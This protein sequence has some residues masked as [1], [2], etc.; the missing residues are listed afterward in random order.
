MTKKLTH[1]ISFLLLTFLFQ[2]S[3]FQGTP[4]KSALAEQSDYDIWAGITDSTVDPKHK[5][6]MDA[7]WSIMMERKML[8]GRFLKSK[9]YDSLTGT[10]V[11]PFSG[12]DVLNLLTFFP[13]SKRYILFGLEDPGYPFDWNA[14]KD[15][16]KKIILRGIS[17]LS[18]HL[19][20]R[21]YFTY[22]KMKEE[23]K[24]PALAGA[25]PVFTA[26]LRRMGKNIID[27]RMEMIQG[28]KETYHGFSIDLYDPATNQKQTLTYFKIFLTGKEGIPGDGVYEYFNALGEKSVFTKSAEYLFHGERRSAFRTLLLNN[29]VQVVQD[30]SG[31]PLRLF[32][33]K[34]WSRILYG[35]YEKSWK[36]SG[37]IEPEYQTDMVKLN[38][39]SNNDPLPFP[40][41][42][43]VLGSRSASQ[44]LILVLRKKSN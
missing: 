8:I 1:S 3:T 23:T 24:K 14:K 5:S 21:N 27:S 25:Y 30:D 28:Q 31:F 11:Y 39:D 15:S 12:I 17:S 44:S 42:Y 35:R 33:E 37:A 9:S 18:S 43:G 13:N 22:R 26:F 29:T 38:A 16:D 41:G 19:A 20:G 7:S 4:S 6:E 10:V 40:F 2:C 32:P 34:D 36:L